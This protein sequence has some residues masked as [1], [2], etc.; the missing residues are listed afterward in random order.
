MDTLPLRYP[1][2]WMPPPWIP[3]PKIPCPLEGTWD[4]RYPVPVNRMTYACKNITFP[5]LRWRAVNT[6]S[7][8]DRKYV[9]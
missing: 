3:S 5:Q 1:T 8:S 4:Q 7:G 9:K 2:P 6:P